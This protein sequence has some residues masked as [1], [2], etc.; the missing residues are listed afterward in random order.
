MYSCRKLKPMQQK[1]T[2]LIMHPWPLN[3][4]QQPPK[5]NNI[6]KFIKNI[7]VLCYLSHFEF[8]I[9]LPMQGGASTVNIVA[10]FIPPKASIDL[11][12]QGPHE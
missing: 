10:L 11:A 1:H 8:L 12:I 3:F 4:A 5:M 2:N 6:E 7:F 9:C